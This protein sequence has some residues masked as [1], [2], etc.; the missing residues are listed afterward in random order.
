MLILIPDNSSIYTSQIQECKKMKWKQCYTSA[1]CQHMS[2]TLC[3]PLV[4][5]FIAKPANAL[6]YMQ[7]IEWSLNANKY[8]NYCHMLAIKIWYQTWIWTSWSIFS[9]HKLYANICTI[10][11]NSDSIKGKNHRDFSNYCTLQ[12]K[13]ID[14][15]ICLPNYAILW[16]MGTLFIITL[17]GTR[18]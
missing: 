17:C 10:N 5:M 11:V 8:Y 7:Y 14:R 1:N 13:H 3:W 6:I 18:Y 16:A 4:I 12:Y 9:D 2:L 15:Y